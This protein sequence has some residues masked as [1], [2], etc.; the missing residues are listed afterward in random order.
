MSRGLRPIQLCET[1]FNRST[2]PVSAILQSQLLP[3]CS[4]GVS[5]VLRSRLSWAI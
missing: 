2:S 3:Q 1:T 4:N 5:N